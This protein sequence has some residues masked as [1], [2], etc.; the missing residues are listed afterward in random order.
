MCIQLIL[1]LIIIYHILLIYENA[2]VQMLWSFLPFVRI[3][4]TDYNFATD[5][6]MSESSAASTIGQQDERNCRDAR[7]D[8][9]ARIRRR[10]KAL[11]CC[12]KRESRSGETVEYDSEEYDYIVEKLVVRRVPLALVAIPVDLHDRRR[13]TPSTSSQSTCLSTAGGSSTTVTQTTST[14]S[15]I[16][17][18]AYD[19]TASKALHF[20]R[21]ESQVPVKRQVF[22]LY[23][24]TNSIMQ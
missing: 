11:I 9:S 2:D 3:N 8:S 7:D 15:T 18:T 17:R 4:P 24:E 10:L 19:F 23:L 20:D 13:Q 21:H 1:I 12:F 6:K 22:P 14:M 5:L 16:D